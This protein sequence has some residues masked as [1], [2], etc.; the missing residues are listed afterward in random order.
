ML[1]DIV[2]CVEV[3]FVDDLNLPMLA[4]FIDN[5]SCKLCM[6]YSSKCPRFCKDG[7]LNNA[8]R[9]TCSV[10]SCWRSDTP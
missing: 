6:F 10:S 2:S 3:S 7:E 1:H 5:N 8:L 9:I 4:G